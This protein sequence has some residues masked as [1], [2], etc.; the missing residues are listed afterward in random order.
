MRLG[1][2]MPHQSEDTLDAVSYRLHALSSLCAAS[3]PA[4]TCPQGSQVEHPA[5]LRCQ[6]SS[7]APDGAIYGYRSV[8]L[9]L[10]RC[11]ADCGAARGGSGSAAARRAARSRKGAAARRATPAELSRRAPPRVL[12][13]HLHLHLP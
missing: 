3:D 4:R 6:R 1:I 7:V 5:L 9:M 13:Q 12:S 8:A 2:A 11:W 10:Q